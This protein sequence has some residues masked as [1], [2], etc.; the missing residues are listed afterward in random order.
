MQYWHW[1]MH[2]I[3]KML[4][5]WVNFKN[6]ASV[7]NFKHLH[8]LLSRMIRI[9]LWFCF[10]KER[11]KYIG[12]SAARRGPFHWFFSH[13]NRD[14]WRGVFHL[15]QQGRYSPV[16]QALR[17]PT[18]EVESSCRRLIFFLLSYVVLVERIDMSIVNRITKL[19]FLRQ[20]ISI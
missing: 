1:R 10:Q 4:L 6:C 7:A 14:M 5:K 3:I 12:T 13:S 16:R 8:I 9:F 11:K 19:K 15:L 2:R 20:V 18:S 17:N